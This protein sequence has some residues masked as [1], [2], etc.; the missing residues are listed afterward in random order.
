MD[1]VMGGRFRRWTL[2]ALGVLLVM[3][4]AACGSTTSSSTSS[5]SSGGDATASS[6]STSAAEKLKVAFVYA[7]AVDNQGWDTGMDIGRQQLEAELGDQIEVT[8]KDS[9]PDGP[10][11]ATVIKQLIDDGN[12]LIFLTS[13][14]QQFAV[15][16]LAP[17]YP[18]VKFEQVMA[19]ETSENV[20]NFDAS[21]VE[22]FYVAGMAAAAAAS[23]PKIGLVGGFPLTN[24]LAQVNALELGAQSMK[25]SATVQMVWT[26]DWNSL[27]K[28]QSAA[29]GL[30]DSGVKALTQFTTGPGVAPVAKATN[31]PWVA[32][33]VD[34]KSYAP[35]QYLTSV[36]Y[37]WGPFFIERT[38][39]AL[40][41]T[42]KSG[43]FFGTMAN[44][45]IKLAPWGPAY[46]KLDQAT[47]DKI[48]AK[49][50]SFVA[51]D[52]VFVGPITDRDGKER[53]A[54]GKSPTMAEVGMTD[55]VVKGVLGTI[56]KM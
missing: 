38:K 13:F 27:P 40:D 4:L 9:V 41:G 6:S 20:S 31:T 30:V 35:D 28:A 22:G 17:K 36:L 48:Q 16:E 53:V 34:Q 33:E 3:A 45:T 55:Y 1:H 29:Q 51:G 2:A 5:S 24:Q 47:K 56:P 32:Y 43:A 14:G 49:I 8:Y 11:D 18:D 12:K 26:N 21:A 50:D 54:A 25:P 10:Q 37:N 23:E 19:M 46:D 39:A 7:G 44:D 15:K 42:W 52:P